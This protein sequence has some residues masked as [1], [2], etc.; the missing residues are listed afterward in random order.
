M[1]HV[2]LFF[3]QTATHIMQFIIAKEKMLER[4]SL[5]DYVQW[6]RNKNA[7][8]KCTSNFSR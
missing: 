2:I 1:K 7:N 5:G 4:F 8:T 6:K 3:D